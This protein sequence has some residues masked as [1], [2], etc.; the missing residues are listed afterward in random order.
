MQL[1][2]QPTP[3]TSHIY[4]A[5]AIRGQSRKHFMLK[6]RETFFSFEI[7]QPIDLQHQIKNAF[8]LMHIVARWVEP[9]SV[10]MYNS[11]KP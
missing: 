4:S 6:L 3:L 5:C 1:I 11:A 9:V 8:R 2:D 7:F 10:A